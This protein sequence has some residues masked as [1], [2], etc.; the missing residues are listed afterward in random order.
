MRPINPNSKAW[1][2]DLLKAVVSN[3]EVA[4]IRVITI[5]VEDKDD[6]LVW[7]HDPK[8]AYLVKSGY[9]LALES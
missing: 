2:V 3:R 6:C 5:L 7:H 4:T 8:G 9:Q 1:D